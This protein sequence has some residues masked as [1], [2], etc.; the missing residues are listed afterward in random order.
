M[1]KAICV[2]KDC[3]L[4]KVIEPQLPYRHFLYGT[5]VSDE[6]GRFSAE[7]YVFTSIITFMASHRVETNNTLYITI[8]LYPE[9]S[10]TLRAATYL[11][12]TGVVTSGELYRMSQDGTIVV[13]LSDLDQS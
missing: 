12:L 2:V 11:K 4:I 5:V 13:D 10:M 8:G 6:R 3:T 9:I 1:I 7:D